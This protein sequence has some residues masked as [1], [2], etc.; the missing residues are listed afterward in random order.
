ML[1]LGESRVTSLVEGNKVGSYAD[2]YELDIQDA[3]ACD[4][5]HRQSALAI[6]A[7][8]MIPAPDKQDDLED[9]IDEAKLEKKKVPLWKLFASFGI[10]SA[11]K[12]AGKAL[13]TH[14]GSLKKIRSASVE[15]LEAVDDV[16]EKTAELIHDYL[17]SN[18]DEIDRLMK[19]VEPELPQTGKLTGKKFCFSGGFPEGKRHWEQLVESKG[20]VCAGGVSKKIDYLVAGTGSGSKSDKAKKLGIPIL[21]TKKLQKLM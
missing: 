10:E 18:S 15:K 20:G 5:T 14:F 19:Y 1:G 8:H 9:L 17:D 2:F 21:D 12:A 13:S 3:M 11:G 7:I 16:G 6:A 4:L